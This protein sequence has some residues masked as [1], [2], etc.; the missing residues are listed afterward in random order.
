MYRLM[1][2]GLEDINPRPSPLSFYLTFSP[3]FLSYSWNIYIYKKSPCQCAVMDRERNFIRFFSFLFFL[4]VFR[5]RILSRSKRVFGGSGDDPQ[6]PGKHG[7]VGP[8][9]SSGGK[10]SRNN[11]TRRYIFNRPRARFC[12]LCKCRESKSE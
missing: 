5:T 2:S 9:C 4:W 8:W 1:F 11:K 12:Y 7:Q 6:K 3:Y 10:S